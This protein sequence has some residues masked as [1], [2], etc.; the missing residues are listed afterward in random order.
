MKARMHEENLRKQE[1][2]VKKQESMRKGNN[3][4][5]VLCFQPSIL[6]TI[7]HELALRHK[8]DLE[9]IQAE[10]KARAHGQSDLFY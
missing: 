8:Y 5:Y 3:M 4:F 9:R 7:E 6:A 1:E 10:V 2:S